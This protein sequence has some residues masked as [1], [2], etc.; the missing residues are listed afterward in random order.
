MSLP[1][2]RSS[3][4]TAREKKRAQQKPWLFVGF[5]LMKL[6]LQ[7]SLNIYFVV[8]M[9]LR[10]EGVIYSALISGG[11]MSA[12]MLGYTFSHIGMRFARAKAGKLVNFSLPLMMAIVAGSAPFSRTIRSTFSAVSTFCG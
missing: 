2:N 11:V 7:L 3:G 10:V 5:S 4:F 1:P 8:I 9:Q 6:V 12:I